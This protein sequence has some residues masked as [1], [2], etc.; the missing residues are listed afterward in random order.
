[1]NA[2][3]SPNRM[4]S[5][6][7]DEDDIPPSRT[8]LRHLRLVVDLLKNHRL[9]VPAEE[10]QR[11]VKEL[12]ELRPSHDQH[13]RSLE[14]VSRALSA[15]DKAEFTLNEKLVSWNAT[16][17]RLLTK[18]QRMERRDWETE[19]RREVECARRRLTNAVREL[20]ATVS[21]HTEN[22]LEREMRLIEAAAGPI[23][24]RVW[25]ED[26]VQSP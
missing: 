1:M 23:P 20:I 3:P 16:D 19:L 12:E 17:T 8:D 11:A 9:V 14:A 18:E 2:A 25:M 10:V 5:T 21:K 6:T 15:M 24:A 22:E 13:V 26:P 7:V 4:I